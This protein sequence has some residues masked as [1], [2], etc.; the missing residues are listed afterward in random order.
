MSTFDR[1]HTEL[2]F[3]SLGFT[4]VPGEMQPAKSQNYFLVTA[5]LLLLKLTCCKHLHEYSKAVSGECSGQR[6]AIGKPVT[7]CQ[8]HESRVSMDR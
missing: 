7:G 3:A 1:M 8:L 6:S 5:L 4:F 2:I